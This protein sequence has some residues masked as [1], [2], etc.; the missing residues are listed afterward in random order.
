MALVIKTDS[1]AAFL[2]TKMAVTDGVTTNFA[3]DGVTH[4]DV[5]TY[6]AQ[7]EFTEGAVLGMLQKPFIDFAKSCGG[8]GVMTAEMIIA[9]YAGFPVGLAETVAADFAKAYGNYVVIPD[10]MTLMITAAPIA[11]VFDLT[12][13]EPPVDPEIDHE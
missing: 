4:A 12:I 13:P 2:E 8:A 9:K 7:G 11:S 1:V 10:G 3:I 6:P 5:I